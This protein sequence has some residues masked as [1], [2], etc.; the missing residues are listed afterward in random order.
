MIIRERALAAR[1]TLHFGFSVPSRSGINTAGLRET[2]IL[3][4][5]IAIAGSQERAL[6]RVTRYSLNSTS[7]QP[8][9][10]EAL[11]SYR[12]SCEPGK[13]VHHLRFRMPKLAELPNTTLLERALQKLNA[14][15]PQPQ[16]AFGLD[17]RVQFAFEQ[18]G[19]AKSRKPFYRLSQ[20]PLILSSWDRLARLDFTLDAAADFASL[21][22]GERVEARKSSI[23]AMGPVEHVVVFEDPP[24][25]REWLSD[26]HTIRE[27]G[28]SPVL[29]AIVIYARVVFAHPHTNGNGRLARAMLYSPLAQTSLISTP[30]LALGAVFDV[31]REVLATALLQLAKSS[32]WKPFVILLVEL[33][34]R[35]IN[36]VR[37][38]LQ[39]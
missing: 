31:Y 1:F 7:L 35:S 30:C 27:L 11:L 8:P 15:F 14:C 36:M 34:E 21:L 25:S 26:I 33:L 19:Q 38:D 28:L 9:G 39:Q 3:A 2:G 22:C 32:H 13:H 12:N 10:T 6:N 17:Q 18:A 4:E 20:E 37:K 23:W 16:A 5:R 24:R 29:E